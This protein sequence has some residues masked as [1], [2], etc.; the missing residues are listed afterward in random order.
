MGKNDETE[1]FENDHQNNPENVIKIVGCMFKRDGE[2][3]KIK[4]KNL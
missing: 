3:N 2:D 1:V 4:I